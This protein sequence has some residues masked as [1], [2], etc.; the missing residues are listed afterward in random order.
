M[1]IPRGRYGRRARS[2]PARWAVASHRQRR[3]VPRSVNWRPIHAG[4]SDLSPA[5]TAPWS[6]AD[7]RA[8]Q[9]ADLRPFE[10]HRKSARRH[11]QRAVE[12]DDLAVEHLVVDDVQ[13][14]AAAYSS[15]RP[16][17]AGTGRRP[18]APRGRARAAPASSG[19]SNVPGAIVHTRIPVSARSR[20]AGQRHPD[21][22]ALGRRIGD[23][24]DLAVEGG[25][26][27][28]VDA[29]PALADGPAARWRPSRCG[30]PDADVEGADQVDR[31]HASRT[32]PELVRAASARRPA[33]PSRCPRSRPAIRRPPAAR[34][35]ASTAPATVL[36][37]R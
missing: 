31:D 26:R 7:R 37:R 23:L 6:G 28:S 13:R 25:D 27:G 20:A 33:R 16:S 21:D 2:D 24:A 34:A 32:P 19:V 10:P 3:A 18:P 9:Q 15:G 36:G 11:P 1:L 5:I 12:P 4:C 8:R 14:P 22:P 29:H 30:Q 17:R 35:A